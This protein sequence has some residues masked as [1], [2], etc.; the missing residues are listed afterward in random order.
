MN[1]LTFFFTVS[2]VV[3]LLVALLVCC[4]VVDC[5]AVVPALLICCDVV[6]CTPCT[7]EVPALLVCCDVVRAK[8]DLRLN[9]LKCC[10]P[11]HLK[12]LVDASGNGERWEISRT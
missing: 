2:P 8:C 7:A 6:D 11:D 9:W 4:G 10:P 5:K 12:R 1:L 3:P